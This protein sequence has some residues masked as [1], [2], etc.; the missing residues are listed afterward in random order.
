M[1]FPSSG[2]GNQPGGAQHQ[3]QQA[4]APGS[5]G[6][7]QPYQQQGGQAQQTQYQAFQPYQAPA[8]RGPVASLNIGTLL[9][10]GVT[11]L[12]MVSYFISFSDEAPV[13]TG[14][15]FQLIGGLLAALVAL[16]KAPKIL[17]FAALA[18]VLGALYML[19]VMVRVPDASGV[20]TVLL[21]LSMLQMLVAVTALLVEYGV[22]TLPTGPKQQPYG[23][24]YAQQGP[25][26]HPGPYAQQGGA[27]QFQQPTQYGPAA[28]PG[29]QP[30]Q[31]GQP[32][33]PG[34]QPTAYAAQQGQFYAAQAPDSGEQHNSGT[35]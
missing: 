31:A 19:L 32:A 13:G 1:T 18:S 17:P 8:G 25:Y 15:Q 4:P 5:G 21:I 33:Q 22:V 9:A 3:Q 34:Q 26:A 2:S 14:L 6:F 24:P 16:P 27:G 29:N 35:Q 20:L 11:L 23:H 10:L 28:A 30:G 7:Q 12:A